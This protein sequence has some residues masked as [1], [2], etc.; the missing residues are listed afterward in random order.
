MNHV[1]GRVK[2]IEYGSYGHIMASV[3]PLDN[4]PTWLTSKMN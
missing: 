3:N 2:I 4:S 1:F